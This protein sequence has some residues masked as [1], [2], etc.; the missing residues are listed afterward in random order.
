VLAVGA[1]HS[2]HLP[3]QNGSLANRSV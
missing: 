1:A 3:L 2:Q